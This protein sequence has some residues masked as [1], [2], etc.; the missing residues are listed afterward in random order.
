MNVGG[1]DPVMLVPRV[2]ANPQNFNFDYIGSAMLAL[3]EVL[4]LEGW[5]EIRDII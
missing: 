3:F 1:A 2:W 5:L 4:S